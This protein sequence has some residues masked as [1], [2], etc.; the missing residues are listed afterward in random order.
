MSERPVYEI[1]L[2]PG[3]PGNGAQAT[4]PGFVPTPPS[5]Y[6][7]PPGTGAPPPVPPSL[8][9]APPPSVPGAQPPPMSRP[10]AG[11]DAGAV[12]FPSGAEAG[13]VPFPSA[14]EP[15]PFPF[16]FPTEPAPH[17]GAVPFPSGDEPAFTPDRPGSSLPPMPSL[18]DLIAAAAEREQPAGAALPPFGFGAPAEPATA[19]SGVAPPPPLDQPSSIADIFGSLVADAP[20]GSEQPSAPAP[21]E[22][23]SWMGAS[24]SAVLQPAEEPAPP[25][26]LESFAG[27]IPLSAFDEAILGTIPESLRAV[28]PDLIAALRSVGPTRASDLH[29]TAGSP[30]TLRVDGSLRSLDM[31]VWDAE[32]TS[33]ALLSALD[34]QRREQFERENELDW[35]LTI[36]STERF[37]VNYSVQRGTVAAAFRI[38]P[39]TIK[40][41]RELGMPDEVAR[42]ATLPRGL[43]LVTGPTG[44]GKS[45]TLAA[46]VDLV[47]QT[48]ADHIVTVE[49][50][51]EYMHTSKKA[52]V[53][54][55]EVGQDT[56]SFATAL[57][58]VLRQDPDVILIGEMRDLETISVALTAAETGHLV[59]AT[60]HTQSAAQTI[61]RVIDVFP[62]HQQNQVRAQLSVTLRGVVCQTLVRSATGQGRVVATEVM[63]TTPAVANVIREG[64]TYQVPSML[65]AGREL[66]MHTMDQ[67]LADLLNEGKITYDAALERVQDLETFTRLARRRQG[68]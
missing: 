63:F 13:A 22:P 14:Q 54:Q 37:R 42:F 21:Q 39:T 35:A 50:P 9:S 5:A 56:A 32:K 30:P 49:D 68:E 64:K 36:S 57:K 44:S 55:R 67:D 53:K 58:H 60:L 7:P 15:P 31:P 12:P 19:R 23:A 6:G 33:A 41:L 16:P 51:I 25:A 62:P 34:P 28:D 8:A 65:Q 46:L 29:I 18:D 48:R 20:S 27:P 4:P 17:A 2:E 1:P 10:T 47:N 66:G 45:T 40:S 3:V 59:F 24:G 26:D 43:V 11:P 38:I 61:D 52:L